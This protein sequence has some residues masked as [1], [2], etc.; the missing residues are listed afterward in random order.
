LVTKDSNAA[1]ANQA[2][3]LLLSITMI[4]VVVNHECHCHLS[5][6][7]SSAVVG[8]EGLMWPEQTKQY[9]RQPLNT[10]ISVVINFRRCHHQAYEH[11]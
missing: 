4:S 7:A 8:C 3:P 6:P 11:E 1:R 2:V 10:I 5:S 9:H